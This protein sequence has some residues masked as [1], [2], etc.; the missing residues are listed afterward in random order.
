MVA[1]SVH[2]IFGSDLRPNG[3]N[4]LFWGI[5]WSTRN[6]TWLKKQASPL[7]HIHKKDKIHNVDRTCFDRVISFSLQL[8]GNMHAQ[9]AWAVDPALLGKH[10][11]F[12]SSEGRRWNM[13]EKYNIKIRQRIIWLFAVLCRPLLVLTPLILKKFKDVGTTL[14]LWRMVELRLK[15]RR[16]DVTW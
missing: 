1:F 15:G 3:P 10:M 4:P 8:M 5:V 9:V 12:C 14:I 13:K 2:Y 16:Q 11:M 7:T 6:K